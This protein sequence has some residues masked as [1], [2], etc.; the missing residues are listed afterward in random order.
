MRRPFSGLSLPLSQWAGE[1][2]DANVDGQTAN[3]AHWER[4]ADGERQFCRAERFVGQHEG[5]TA[6]EGSVRAIAEELAGEPLSLLKEKIN[7]KLPGGGGFAAHVDTPAYLE[8]A[9]SH[10]TAMVAVD[11]ADA[12]NGAL[13]IAPGLWGPREDGVLSSAEDDVLRYDMQTCGPGDVVLFSGWTP[14]RSAANTDAE[15]P[16]RAIFFTYNLARDGDHRAAYY[17]A[18][19][20]GAHEFDSSVAVSFQS[21]FL[22][23]V[24]S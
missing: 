13:E 18:K 5:L 1:L 17:A 9:P 10:V 19:D 4:T 23:T 6:L 2:A 24:V 16:R 8:Y 22:G 11:A 14:H 12:A 15:R 21:D 20:E 7:Y 3:A